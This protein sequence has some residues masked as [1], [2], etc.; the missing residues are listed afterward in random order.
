MPQKKK[1][2]LSPPEAR[3]IL[4]DGDFDSRFARLMEYQ[5]Q[6]AAEAR[7]RH[8]EAM[9]RMD[10]LEAG[11]RKTRWRIEEAEEARG[12]AAEEMF[13]G[14]LPALLKKAGM[15]VDKVEPRR[16]RKQDRE[17]DFVARNGAANFVGE[18]KVRF[19]AKHLSR[20]RDL[21]RQFRNDYPDKAGGRCMGLCA[22]WWWTRTRQ[23]SPAPRGCWWW[24]ERENSASASS[25]AKCGTTAGSEVSAPVGDCI[26][27]RNDSQLP[28]RRITWKKKKDIGGVTFAGDPR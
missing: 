4:G 7:Q 9:E 10:K 22:A 5:A 23:T 18:V 8:A 24:R 27:D 14:A 13:R 15:K 3:K 17:Y 19:R 2:R 20:L 11:D 6:S 26:P 25:R 1:T 28:K 12:R 21:L 16:L